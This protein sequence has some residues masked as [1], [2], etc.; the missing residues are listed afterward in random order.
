[1]EGQPAHVIGPPPSS[2]E[3][4]PNRPIPSHPMGSHI[5]TSA[6]SLFGSQ[7]SP[8]LA[9][10]PSLLGC[11]LALS[12]PSVA[13]RDCGDC[14]RSP[15]RIPWDHILLHDT[16]PSSFP[17]SAFRPSTTSRRG[18]L[19]VS[20]P[21]RRF[22]WLCA[23]MFSLPHIA[24]LGTFS[25]MHVLMYKFFSLHG[26]R[27]VYSSFACSL[28]HPIHACHG[29]HECLCSHAPTKYVARGGG[30]DSPA[31][32]RT[33]HAFQGLTLASINASAY[34]HTYYVLT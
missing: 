13:L 11:L 16:R 26:H 10:Q 29:C 33:R 18:C 5:P 28:S 34:L 1:M 3:L 24:Y 4:A 21:Q 30:I 25:C 27:C 17:S 20:I 7:A 8:G 2:S 15:L 32:C 19:P 23:S 14:G 12:P 22:V 9:S 31:Q 6:P